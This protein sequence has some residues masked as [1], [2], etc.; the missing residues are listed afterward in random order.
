MHTGG[1]SSSSMMLKRQ[2]ICS[3]N[4]ELST[5]GD[6]PGLWSLSLA[7]ITTSPSWTTPSVSGSRAPSCRQHSTRKAKRTG[8]PFWKTSRR[9]SCTT[10]SDLHKVTSSISK[11]SCILI[12]ALYLPACP[13][14]LTTA[15]LTARNAP[16]RYLASFITRFTYGIEVDEEYM[17]LA[18]VLSQHTQQALR[19]GRWIVDS[20][21]ARTSCFYLHNLKLLIKIIS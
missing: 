20:I 10:S 14:L 19:P 13:F 15:R 11:G 3:T 18:D 21:P 2:K 9:S 6:Q 17:R 4:A 16:N 8:A 1:T 5:Q 12:V 7:G